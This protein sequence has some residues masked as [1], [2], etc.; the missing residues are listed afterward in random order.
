MTI[1]ER[2]K[3]RRLD[4][5]MSQDDLARKMGYKTRN[6]IYQ[7]EQKDNMKL[8]LVEKF[9]EALETTPSYLMGWDEETEANYNSIIRGITY[10]ER[11]KKYTPEEIIRALDF[12]DAFENLTPDRQLAIEALL[13]S[14]Q[15]DPSLPRKPEETT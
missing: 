6:A 11:L 12:L 5:A 4:L 3:Q 7:F 2:I 8:S 9:A 1:G 13:K 15:P 10:G 14:V